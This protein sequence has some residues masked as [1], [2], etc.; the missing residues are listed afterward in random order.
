M[1]RPTSE[2]MRQ[3]FYLGR[4]FIYFKNVP[5]KEMPMSRTVAMLLLGLLILGLLFSMFALFQ[6]RFVEALLI[7]PLLIFAYVV[8]RLGRKEA[9]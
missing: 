5:S 8:S 9:E 3:L 2:E 4:K 6:G 7:Y 1:R